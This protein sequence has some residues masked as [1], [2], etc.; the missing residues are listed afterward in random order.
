MKT[1]HLFVSLTL[2]LSLALALALLWLLSYTQPAQADP[3]ILYVA[4]DG[5]D[6]NNCASVTSRCRTIQR[7]VD[8]AQPGDE[9]R[10]AAGVYTGVQARPVPPGYP[11]PPLT[12]LITQVVYITKTVTVRGGYTTADWNTPDPDAH[13]TTLDA[14][15]L[16]RVM[17]IAGD[18]SPTVEGLHITGGDAAGLGGM[19]G[20][21]GGGGVYI[22]SATTTIS[23]NRVF[24]NVN[25]TD[26]NGGG[27]YLLWSP[28]T[29]SGNTVYSNTAD[30]GGGL[31]LDGSDATLSGNTVYS[32]T[33]T[34]DGGGLYLWDSA[35]TLSGNTVSANTAHDRG[36]GLYLEVSAA[37][38]N[39]NTVSSNTADWGGGLYLTCSAATLSGNTVSANTATWG[40]GGLLLAASDATL[41]GNTV[42]SNT[43]YGDGGGLFLVGSA[44][45]L[46]N[47]IVADNRANDVGSGL[48]VVWYS[49]PRLLHTTLA[50]NIGGD[51]SGVHIVLT[52]TVAM[53]NTILVSHT[54]GITVAAGCTATLE[55]TLWGG[56]TPWAN[57]S[58]TGGSGTINTNHDYDGN[59]VFVNPNAGDYH[60]ALGSAAMD[61]G[62]NAGVPTDKGG[63]P[64]PQGPAPDLGAYELQYFGLT[65]HKAGS[66]GG[67]VTSAPP[68]INCGADCTEPYAKGTVVTL[69]AVPDAGSVFA[70]WSG[71][72]SGSNP[73]TTVTVDTDRTCTATFNPQA[74]VGGVTVP[75]GR[76]AVACPWPALGLVA[77]VGAFGAAMLLKRRPA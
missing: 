55:S 11:N 7:A 42:S 37:T 65:V 27:L 71:D 51:G 20:A 18:I 69:T 41:N 22:I 77:A 16:G 59:P 43:A 29:L 12:N 35:A 39:G 15:G 48:Y 66:G 67:T 5:D 56:G 25:T 70:G 61:Q 40:G 49:S 3:G 45:T 53:T 64:R 62:V 44:A 21:N 52:S 19:P 54:V 60:I 50:R 8:V 38:L 6:A 24:S 36:G 73:N 14:Q 32:N 1:K 72:C 9:I 4:P 26:V 2:G 58:N 74:P 68:G 28:A 63:V 31:Y 23:N 47:T 57:G 13:P 34:W 76:P 30:Y 75:E 33:A 46:T 10:V 17:V